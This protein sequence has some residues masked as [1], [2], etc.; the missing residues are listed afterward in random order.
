[1][2]AVILILIALN[3]LISWKGF[4]DT[5][6]YNRFDL[7]VGR[8]LRGMEYHR[9]I[10]SGFLH[11]GWPHLV[12]NM[13]ALYAFSLGLIS[14][15][16]VWFFILVYFISLAGGK[17]FSLFAHRHH[18]DYNS[19]GASGG[20]NGVIFASIAIFPGM[21][22]GLFFLPLHIP[23]WIFGIVYIVYTIYGVRSGK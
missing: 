1:M 9:I 22:I 23:A 3:F 18:A 11:T 19:V 2:A 8:V 12:W 13:I 21:T 5:F 10:S 16:G 7:Q 14:Q 17:M 15:T 6:F 20:V 4:R